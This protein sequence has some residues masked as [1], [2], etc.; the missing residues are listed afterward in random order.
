MLLRCVLAWLL[1]AIVVPAQAAAWPGSVK[2]A[3][4]D[5]QA[6]EAPED[7][8]V[9][10]TLPDDWSRRWPGF[11]GVVWYR[12]SWT[13][14]AVRDE[15]G[16]RGMGQAEAGLLEAGLFI[17]YLSMTGAISVNGQWLARDASLVEP[18]SRSWNLPRYFLLAPPLLREGENSLLV[19]VS[20]FAADQPGLGTVLVGAPE[21]L[22]LTYAHA[23]TERQTLN[24]AGL[25]IGTALGVMFLLVWLLRRSETAYGWYAIAQLA[26]FLPAWNLLSAS[27]WPFPDTDTYAKAVTCLVML[28]CSAYALFVLRFCGLRWP[29]RETALWLLVALAWAGMIATPHAARGE[30]R[31]LL[32]LLSALILC[33]AQGI[34][35][36]F[37]WTRGRTDQRV[38]SLCLGVACAAGVHDMLLMLSL[39][40]GSTYYSTATEYLSMIG[41][42]VV[43]AWNFS[44]SLHRIERFNA[45]L[46]HNIAEA[47]SELAA[48]LSREHELELVHARL[49]ERVNLVHDLHDGLG[50]MLTG[51]I[52]ELEQAPEKLPSRR[53]LD[54]LRSL[55]DDLRLIIDSASAQHYGEQSLAEMIAPLRHRMTRLFEAH[56]IAAHWRIGELDSVRLTPAQNLDVL[57]LLQE[58]LANVLRHS[59]AERVEIAIEADAEELRIAVRDNGRGIAAGEGEGTGMRSMQARARRLGA[60]LSVASG[61]AGAQVRLRRLHRQAQ[62][63]A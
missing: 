57:R 58:A 2:A 29:R 47:R 35:I 56:A 40:G 3:R 50:G 53:V 22:R 54:M 5:W 6:Q 49:G 11:D 62:D 27:V 63:S 10:V 12:L 46:Q 13:V 59:G 19:R 30:M 18:L 61:A 28:N 60:V 31:G 51:N 20:G 24:L 38:L 37:A 48:T 26:W 41:V 17:D 1:L 43:L 7:G 45:E 34:F 52:A 15:A 25:A 21:P 32:T 44:R 9:G 39:I 8:W 42:A 4:S 16:L 36:G 55:R 23:Y 14:P 33:T